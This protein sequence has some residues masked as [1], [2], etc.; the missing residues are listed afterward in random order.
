[1]A[2]NKQESP[3]GVSEI[4]GDFREFVT[5]FKRVERRLDSRTSS[6]SISSR[7]IDARQT[8]TL[9]NDVTV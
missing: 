3:K 6:T 9:K 2:R 5:F 7:V 8:R 4:Y 1:M